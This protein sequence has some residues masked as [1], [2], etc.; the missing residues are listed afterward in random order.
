MAERTEDALLAERTEADLHLLEARIWEPDAEHLLDRLGLR[1]GSRCVDLG[2]GAAGI[3]APL[4]RRTGPLGSVVGV[5]ADSAL[6]SAARRHLERQGLENVRL[7]RA[8]ARRN[9]LS[10][11]SFD[12]VH[13][14]FLLATL[15]GAR[16][17]VREIVSLVR[18]GGLVALEEPDAGSW[19]CY[20]EGAPF[21]TL[22]N[23]VL[24]AVAQGGGDFNAGRRVFGLLERAGLQNVQLRPALRAFQNGH[25]YMR[26][27][28]NW[29]ETLRRRILEG[30]I[31]SPTALRRAVAGYEK[32]LRLPGS[33]MV[34]YTVM[35]AWGRK[36]AR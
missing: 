21:T 31:L 22:R 35:Q 12:L 4:S 23:A 17:L 36:A 8:D 25:P 18:P 13:G 2:C 34:T 1:P 19:A 26:A 28:L 10:R 15:G 32:F 16:A 33:Y 24:E 29:V 30:E 27:P 7:H 14:R 20:P 6:L 3:L 11:E 9:G 5:D